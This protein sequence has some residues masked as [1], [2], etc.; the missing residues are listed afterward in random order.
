MTDDRFERAIEELKN[1]A[2]TPEQ[3]EAA[4]ARVRQTLETPFL[5]SCLE[6]Q[7]SLADYAA[8][9]LPENRR[10]LTD[11][12]LS[13]CPRCRAQLAELKGERKTAP[14]PTTRSRHWRWPALAAAA[15]LALGVLYVGR[16]RLDR[17]LAPGG[18]RAT[19]ASL[20]G[21]LHRVPA[22]VMQAGT[23]VGE[24]EIIRTAPG[25]RAVLRLSDGSLVDV[26]ERTELFIRGAWSGQTIHL[27][28]GDIIVKAAQQRRGSLHVQT[29]D[30]VASVKGTVFAV[31]AGLG[32][33]VVSVVE[34]AVAVAQPGVNVVLR[35]GQQ[36]ASDPRLASSVQSAVAWSPDAESY[37][38][39]LASFVNL[40]RQI[41]ALPSPALRVESRLLELLPPNP[42][43]YAAI[44]N[45]SQTIR[46]ALPLFDQQAAENPVFA[47]W[48][49]SDAGR[50][51]R[52]LADRIQTV[53][54]LLGDEIVFVIS[55]LA[56]G[57]HAPMVMAEVRQGK[58]PELRVALEALRQETGS[59]A[60]PY[61]ISESLMV[62][63]DSEAHLQWLTQNLSAGTGSPFATALQQRYSRGAG[64][65]LAVN[66]EATPLASSPPPEAVLLGPSQ[67]KHVFFERR[68]AQG[69][70]ENEATLAF[71]GARMGMASL[72][73]NSGSGG[74][75]EYV[76]TDAIFAAY[77]ST[78]EP[79]QIY[80]EITAQLAGVAPS[81]MSDLQA[82][83]ARLGLNFA[84]DLAAACGAEFAFALEGFS[85]SGPVWVA[86]VLI[87]NP[88]TLDQ[89]LRRLIDA[90]NAEL[91]ADEQQRRIAVAQETIDGRTWNLLRAGASPLGA[92]WTYDRGY[93]VAAS[94]RAAATRAI[95]TRNG[96]VPLVWSPA[97]QQQLP[98]SAGLHPS[99]FAWLN[100]RGAL[101][102]LATLAQKPE[103]QTLLAGHAPVLVV[104]NSSTEQ[105][106]AASRTRLSSVI[107]DMMMMSRVN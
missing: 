69:A 76:S 96:G 78:R 53:A 22:G 91:A 30:S 68:T 88:A 58:L 26:N 107:L 25:A 97:L 21:S 105:I 60:L 93:L 9:R 86:S 59:P 13:R 19:V 32:G 45:L 57:E 81:A 48:W 10:V 51:L 24:G 12:H 3:L 62:V 63:S 18:P 79:R 6:F 56:A 33:S 46:E 47:D 5:P 85:V 83:E 99:A 34:G 98:S 106:H 23:A 54:P 66:M 4:R 31:S 39:L 94:D 17:L 101:Q 87:N 104:F 42:V 77:A 44:P 90:Y 11:D 95:A 61:L 7:S 71:H 37:V 20:H 82:A 29:R 15:A 40:E 52:Q 43:V 41:A 80:E 70:E 49:T 102:G 75:A 103:L 84:N 2:V 50:D 92:A 72:L 35:P 67:I 8:G 64:W 36:A 14:P 1:E 65:L 74:A 27:Q 73:A 38:A 16:D 89:S 55:N 100:T 28:R